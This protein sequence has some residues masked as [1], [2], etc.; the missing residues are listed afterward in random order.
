MDM[1]RFIFTLIIALATISGFAQECIDYNKKLHCHIEGEVKE[2]TFTRILLIIGN[3]DPRVVPVDTIWVKDGRFSYDLYIDEPEF[4]QLFACEDYNNGCWMTLDF[5]AEEGDV[6]A[7][8]YGYAIDNAPRP[9]LHSQTPLNTE[10]LAYKRSIEER[11]YIPM[12]L[13]EEALVKAGKLLTAEGAALKRLYDEC[14]DRDSLRTLSKQIE[15]L[16]KDNRLY[17]PEYKA[18]MEKGEELRK[19]MYEY[20]LDYITNNPNLVGLYLLNQARQRF[21]NKDDAAIQPYV[22]LFKNIYDTKYPTNNMAINLRNWIS[23]MDVRVGSRII[24]FT[25][26]DLNGVKHT[27]SKEIEGKIAIVDFWASWCGPCRRTSMSF[28]P[29]Y[30]KYKDKGFIIVGVASELESED[31]RLAVEKDGYPWLNLLALRGVENIWERYGIRG[32]GEVFL[33]DRDGTILAV[34]AT[35]EE[36]EQILKERL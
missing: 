24:D 29:L 18:F 14:E 2:S 10:L 27:L 11:F 33:I 5:F 13:E 34:G 15:Q 25:L 28:I 30:N 20:E 4:Y 26:P 9:T 23:S 36:V 12:R 19:D 8:F 7:T 21:N 3:G 22:D 1:K 6:Y 35:A 16:E 32:A 17:T 31:M